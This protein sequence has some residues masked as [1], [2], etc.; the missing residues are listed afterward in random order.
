MPRTLQSLAFQAAFWSGQL[1]AD[2]INQ[3]PLRQRLCLGFILRQLAYD[4]VYCIL[5][6]YI[7]SSS[8][9]FILPPLPQNFSI[10]YMKVTGM[11]VLSDG[12]K[13]CDVCTSQL[14]E[15]SDGVHI[16]VDRVMTYHSTYHSGATGVTEQITELQFNMM[17]KEA[18][19]DR[20]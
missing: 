10:S 15:K 17:S 16:R 13:T 14:R 18:G 3:F 9:E 1:D 2:W 6:V 4:R 12:M 7:T 19:T 11:S 8:H 5:T 20:F